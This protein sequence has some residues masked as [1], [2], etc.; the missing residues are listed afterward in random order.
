M[1]NCCSSP[2]VGSPSLASTISALPSLP[3]SPKKRKT[4]AKSSLASFFTATPAGL[5]YTYDD[6]QTTAGPKRDLQTWEVLP[7]LGTDGVLDILHLLGSGGSGYTYLCRDVRS[8]ELVAAKFISRYVPPIPLEPCIVC[9]SSSS[10]SST[11]VNRLN[12]P[13]G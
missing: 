3:P 9:C 11:L 2:T 8:G 12:Q 4:R 5:E 13:T 1:G 6:G 10:S 7:E